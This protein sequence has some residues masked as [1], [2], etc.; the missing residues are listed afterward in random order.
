MLNPFDSKMF[1]AEELLIPD[2]QQVIT[3]LFLLIFE[4]LL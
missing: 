1:F 3:G 2:A 4:R